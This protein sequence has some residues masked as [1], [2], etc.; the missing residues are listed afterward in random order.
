VGDSVEA[1]VEG[2]VKLLNGSPKSVREAGVH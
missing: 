1:R 2:D